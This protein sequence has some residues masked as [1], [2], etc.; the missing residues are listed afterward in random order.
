MI[1]GTF[2]VASNPRFQ[3]FHEMML[4]VQNDPDASAQFN[5][6]VTTPRALI[7][8]VARRGIVI[9]EAEAEGVFEAAHRFAKAQGADVYHEARALEDAELDTV[10]GGVSWA[11]VGGF[12]GGIAG[13]IGGIALAVVT[14]PVSIPLGAAAG[15]IALVGLAVGGGTAGALVGGGAGAGLGA[16]AHAGYEAVTGHS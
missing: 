7:A 11:A 4:V 16:G 2:Q 12:A 14:A 3:Q 15:T 8:Y 5:A 9:S 6:E 1:N 13:A 10:N